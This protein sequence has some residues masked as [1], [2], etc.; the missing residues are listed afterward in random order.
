[1]ALADILKRIDRDAEDEAN[2]I[3]LA[4][5]R[6]AEETR[7]R[8]E[9]AAAARHD[10]ELERA[11]RQAE[12]DART[13]LATARLRGRDSILAEKRVLIDRV[14][15]RAVER[16]EALPDADYARLLA[17]EIAAAARGGERVLVAQADAARLSSA[18]PAMLE[19]A[20]A[21]VEVAG[22]TD[23]VAHGVVLEGARMRIE[24]SPWA[25]VVARRAELESAVSEALFGG[26]G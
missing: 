13:R 4:A 5:E 8:A 18:L 24:I 9:T 2:R 21:D 19:Q 1:V 14:L 6:M 16:L 7:A 25:M 22:Q 10:A 11:Q 17:R 12:D 20:G 3:L 23:S 15:S 26:E